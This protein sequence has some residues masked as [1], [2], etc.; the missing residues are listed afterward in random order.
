M[1]YFNPQGPRG[2]RPFDTSGLIY[3][4]DF[5][6]Q[7]PRGPR[8]FRQW[9]SEPGLN[10][11]PQGPRGPRPSCHSQLFLLWIFQST[12]PS[13]ASTRKITDTSAIDRFQSTRPS[14]A[15]TSASCLMFGQLQISIHKALAGLDVH[16][17]ASPNTSGVYFNPQGPRG[18][19]RQPP[20]LHDKFC[21][22]S[23]HKA[24]AGLDDSLRPAEYQYRIISIHKALA[25]LDSISHP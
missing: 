22:I 23:I 15:S 13:R 18:P 12:R 21:Q 11:N 9:D 2:P 10:F 3:P 16:K 19:R 20:Q 6:P 25:G 5:N 8:R 4:Y 17:L 7:G 24:L 14:R 1:I